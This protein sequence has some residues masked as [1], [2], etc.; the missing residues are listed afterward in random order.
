MQSRELDNAFTL[1]LQT[2]FDIPSMF[3]FSA[4]TVL[5]EEFTF[6][7]VLLRSHNFNNS[8]IRSVFVNAFFWTCY[9]SPGIIGLGDS[10]VQFILSFL[11]FNFAIGLLASVLAI[12]YQT[13]WYGYSL[14]IGIMAAFPLLVLSKVQDSE[15]FFVTDSYIF[16]SEGYFYSSLFLITAILLINN[17]KHQ[18]IAEN[19]NMPDGNIFS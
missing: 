19:Q 10:D 2:V 14:R 4:T 5:L 9:T 11:T 16:S 18:N 3:I 17:V 15:A 13:I 1:I 12:K 7:S 8:H 6:R